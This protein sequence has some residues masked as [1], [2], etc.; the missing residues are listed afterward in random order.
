MGDLTLVSDL[1]GI[2]DV[3]L[4]F[5]ALLRGRSCS[6]PLFQSVIKLVNVMIHHTLGSIEVVRFEG[7]L[8]N[9]A[10]HEAPQ[11]LFE[12]GKLPIHW[13]GLGGALV[14]IKYFNPRGELPK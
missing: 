11:L 12:A 5:F 14:L 7:P 3:A 10:I 9:I 13:V 1:Q 8:S 6:Q 4:G 2:F